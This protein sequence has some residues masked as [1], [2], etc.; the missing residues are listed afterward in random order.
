VKA[1][2]T[3]KS[4]PRLV[5]SDF[6]KIPYKIGSEILMTP[7]E[8]AIMRCLK[9]G[10]VIP[11]CEIRYE[12]QAAMRPTASANPVKDKATGEDLF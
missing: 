7:N 1:A 2:A 8:A 6:T 10:A 4:V 3:I 12:D 9:A 5:I 11:G